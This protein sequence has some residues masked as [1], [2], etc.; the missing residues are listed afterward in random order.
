MFAPMTGRA[1]KFLPPPE[2]MP[3]PVPIPP[4]APPPKPLEA[5]PA[6]APETIEEADAELGMSGSAIE[7]EALLD[8]MRVVVFAS[9][10]TFL[11]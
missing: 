1:T 8:V 5:P 2:P 3:L 4:P 7:A 6:I 11:G 9:D 10:F